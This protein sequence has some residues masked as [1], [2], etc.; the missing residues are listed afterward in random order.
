[1]SKDG[2]ELRVVAT[3]A[4]DNRLRN[5]GSPAWQGEKEPEPQADLS[6]SKGGEHSANQ[7]SRPI[8]W[9]IVAFI[10]CSF[11]AAGIG[12]IETAWWLFYGGLAA[13]VVGGIAGWMAGIMEDRGEPGAGE[14]GAEA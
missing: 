14:S 3:T 1:M 2:V 4:Q 8:S 9:V 11:I 7:R 12:L 5:E 6:I 10:C 13:V